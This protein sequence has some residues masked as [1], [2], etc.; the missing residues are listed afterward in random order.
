MTRDDVMKLHAIQHGLAAMTD[1]GRGWAAAIEAAAKAVEETEVEGYEDRERPS[2]VWHDNGARTLESAAKAVRAITPPAPESPA[3]PALDA[4]Q[5]AWVL[6]SIKHYV[7]KH[8]GMARHARAAYK[9]HYSVPSG[10]VADTHDRCADLWQS[11]VAKAEP[12]SPRCPFVSRAYGGQCEKT[13][14]H[15]GL[16]VSLGD[17]FHGGPDCAVSTGKETPR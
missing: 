1:F 12:S 4:G 8:R 2:Q 9:G 13:A 3:A 10:M 6:N 7:A 15:D 11:L 5:R 14:G 16:C 17:G